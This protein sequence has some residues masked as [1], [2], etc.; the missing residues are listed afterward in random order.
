[1]CTQ[2]ESESGFA[3]VVRIPRRMGLWPKLDDEEPLT[4]LHAKFW[5]TSMADEEREWCSMAG[6]EQ[7][8]QHVEDGVVVDWHLSDEI[9]PGCYQL[10]II[11]DITVSKIWIRADYIWVYDHTEAYY[12]RP[13]LP[14]Q[15]PALVIM[16]QSGIGE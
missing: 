1:M 4:Q 6:G 15:P 12:K 10:D 2:Q 9:R 11:K 13:R 5:G 14:G 8:I 3:L 16:G 7:Q